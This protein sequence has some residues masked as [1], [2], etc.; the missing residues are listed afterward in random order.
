MRYDP[1]RLLCKFPVHSNKRYLFP[2]ARHFLHEG[3][4][5]RGLEDQYLHLF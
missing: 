1:P 5:I 2:K 3:K 4:V